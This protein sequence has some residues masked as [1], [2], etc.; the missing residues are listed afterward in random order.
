M[1]NHRLQGDSSRLAS[2]EINRWNRAADR[3]EY[4]SSEIDQQQPLPF[5]PDDR[6]SWWVWLRNDGVDRQRGDC[7]ALGEP[8]NDIDTDDG[9]IDLMFELEAADPDKRPAILVEPVEGNDL[10]RAVIHG[11]AV[12]KVQ[13]GAGRFAQGDV[14]GALAPGDSGRVELLADPGGTEKLLP[15]LVG[16]GSSGTNEVGLFKTPAAGIPAA[17]GFG[18]VGSPYGWGSAACNPIDDSGVVDTGSTTT[19]SNIVTDTI[20]G[21]VAIKAIKVGSHWIVD[22]AS[23]P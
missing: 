23:C 4:A 2:S 18:T 7:V 12:A 15:V 13:A 11:M 10:V 9:T 3:V 1:T 19:I 20:G 6:T 14:S 17:N 8:V 16:V 21:D 22:V 5:L